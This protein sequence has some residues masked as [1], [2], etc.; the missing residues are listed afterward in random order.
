MLNPPDPVEYTESTITEV[1]N[2]FIGD[3]PG[4]GDYKDIDGEVFSVLPNQNSLIV[5]YTSYLIL[6]Q[7]APEVKPHILYALAYGRNGDTMGEVEGI[8]Y[9]PVGR[10]IRQPALWAAICGN[11]FE[12]PVTFWRQLLRNKERSDED[13]LH[14]AWKGRGNMWVF[15]RPDRCVE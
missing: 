5:T 15:V 8:D 13:I 2:V 7:V 14:E 4:L 3:N 9:G 10:I 11:G 6:K 12:N 1:F